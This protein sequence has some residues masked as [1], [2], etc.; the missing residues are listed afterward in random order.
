MPHIGSNAALKFKNM[1]ILVSNASGVA[2]PATVNEA[3]AQPHQ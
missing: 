2:L 1:T 3:H